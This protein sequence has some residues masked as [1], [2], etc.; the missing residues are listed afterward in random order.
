MTRADGPAPRSPSARREQVN[1]WIAAFGG[2]VGC[3]FREQQR[4]AMTSPMFNL[5]GRLVLGSHCYHENLPALL[6]EIRARATAETVGSAMRGLCVRPNYVH[7]NSLALG[8][9]VGREQVRLTGGPEDE[10]FEQV[11]GVMEF[12]SGIARSYRSDGLLLPDESG[13]SVPILDAPAV[14]ELEAALGSGLPADERRQ[15]RRM[16]ATLEL[17]TF[18]LHGEARVGVFHHGPYPLANGDVLVVRELVG[19]REDFYPWARLHHRLPHNHVAS[20]MRL[21]DVRCKIVLFGS[22]TTEPA[23]YA[24]RVVAERVF[25]VDDGEWHPLPATDMQALTDTA[26][27]AQLELYRRVMEWDEAYRIAYGAELY[28]YLLKS[29]GDLLGIGEAFGRSV[30]THFA[31]SVERHL[32]DLRSGREQPLVLQHIATAQ[33]PI[34]APAA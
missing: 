33:G 24:A 16:L 11:A 6:D 3:F 30:R 15:A 23:D 7:L 31:E 28:A 9:L 22:L 20:V 25:V 5:P 8:Y 21:R 34:F 2:S 27:D 13:F 29:F 32:E 12:W 4:S 17:F 1:G 14:A 19:L 18:I 26:A 10:D